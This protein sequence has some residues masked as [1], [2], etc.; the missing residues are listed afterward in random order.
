MHVVNIVTL[1][2]GSKWMMDAGFGGDGATKPV[3]LVHG[4]AVQNLGT[5]EIRLMR[6][7]LDEQQDRSMLYW[8]YEYRNH[9]T[10]EWNAYYAFPEWEF[11]EADFGIVNFYA[12]NSPESIQKLNVLVVKFVRSSGSDVDD[13]VTDKT[14]TSR[15]EIVEKIM[16]HDNLVRRNTGGKTQTVQV[17]ETESQRIEALRSWFGLELTPAEQQAIRGHTKEIR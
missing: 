6:S 12:S 15:A 2:D 11:S 13:I 3:P 9:P 17:L 10:A 8:V 5:Q 4:Q 7:N 14:T 16:L 1:P